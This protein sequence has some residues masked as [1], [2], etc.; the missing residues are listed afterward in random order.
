MLLAKTKIEVSGR[1]EHMPASKDLYY[2][3]YFLSLLVDL[4]NLL[5]AKELVMICC[6]HK[7]YALI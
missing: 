7:S 3:K 5:H 6:C 2:L 1:R 4:V